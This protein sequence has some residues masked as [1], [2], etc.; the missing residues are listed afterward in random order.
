MPPTPPDLP[1]IVCTF[2]DLLEDVVVRLGGPVAP[3]SDTPATITH[4]RGGSAANVAAAVVQAGGR[5]RFVGQVG[6]DSRG[7]ALV[8]SLRADGVD[9]VALSGERTGAVVVLVDHEGERTML[10]DRAAAVALHPDSVRDDWLDGVRVLHLPAYSLFDSPL[11]EAAARL[12][13]HAGLR[14]I[15]VSVDASSAAPLAAFGATQFLR[16]LAKLQPAVLFCNAAEADVL[17]L[18]H[19]GPPRGVTT[20]VVKRGAQPTV[21]LRHDAAPEEVP[22]P[23]VAEVVDTTGAGDAFAAGFLHAWVLGRGPAATV[24]AGHEL[25]ARTLAVLGAGVPAAPAPAVR[26]AR[27]R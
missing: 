8:E 9:V 2:G 17:G 16:L 5:A 11:A 7:R 20:A 10:S 3:G 13:A 15:P 1:R 23:P 24:A 26:R 21:L 25:A 4:A 18:G 22:V 27:R 19:L 6:D 12:V 14:D